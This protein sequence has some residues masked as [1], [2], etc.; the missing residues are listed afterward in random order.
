MKNKTMICGWKKKSNI[1]VLF[2]LIKTC[3]FVSKKLV[4]PPLPYKKSSLN[5]QWTNCCI[6]ICEL[7]NSNIYS[8]WREKTVHIYSQLVFSLIRTH[9]KWTK[10]LSF[11]TSA[12]LIR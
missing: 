9:I 3:I 5:K 4:E 11:G 2:F 8:S 1:K 7:R 6:V 12:N 10:K